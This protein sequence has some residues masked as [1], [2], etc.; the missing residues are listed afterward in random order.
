MAQKTTIDGVEFNVV[1]TE[2]G[3]GVLGP[4]SDRDY[5]VKC[6]NRYQSK[7]PRQLNVR[8]DLT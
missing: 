8:G 3:S 2:T 5:A 7:Y 6:K 4:F 1:D